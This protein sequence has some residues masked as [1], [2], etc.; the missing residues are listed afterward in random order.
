MRYE[1][2]LS[3]SSGDICWINGPFQPGAYNDLDIF[4]GG[5]KLLLEENERALGDNGYCAE[6][7]GSCR[8]R[9]GFRVYKS[10][11]DREAAVYISNKILARQETV[12]A[13][14]KLFDCL[15]NYRHTYDKHQDIF[16]AVAVLVQINIETDSPLFIITAK[17]IC[18]LEPE[19][20]YL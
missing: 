18:D 1:V 14:L 19:R 10:E 11:T 15:N 9:N 2:A 16:T 13:R 5:L 6:D 17:D 20:F 8:T 12:N 7:P 4:R 3:I